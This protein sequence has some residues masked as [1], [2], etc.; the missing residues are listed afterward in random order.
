M[1]LREVY[2]GVIWSIQYT[3]DDKNIFATRMYQWRDAEYL[4]DYIYK[5]KVFIENNPFW[6]GFS[7]ADIIVSAKKDAR[8]LLK[9]INKLYTNTLHGLHPD[10]SDRFYILE[11]PPYNEK[12]KARRKFYGRDDE[13]DSYEYPATVFRFYAI[14][15]DSEQKGVSPAY[16]I[17]GG[18]IKLSDNMPKMKELNQEYNKMLSVQE[19]LAKQGI[20]TKESLYTLNNGKNE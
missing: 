7:V 6:E 12:K 2:P 5:H 13:Y 18:G 17:T 9:Y 19:W 20:K 10:F 16:I 1:E 4:E 8:Y 14:K 3:G 15:L 11:K